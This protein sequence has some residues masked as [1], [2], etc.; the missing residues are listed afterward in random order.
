[1]G[2]LTYRRQDDHVTDVGQRSPHSIQTV[3]DDFTIAC[4]LP[5]VGH[6]LNNHLQVTVDGCL[7]SCL[8]AEAKVVGNGHG[9][10]VGTGDAK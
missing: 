2:K 6:G 9:L 7:A 10:A 8:L 1:M 3:D 5:D 4:I